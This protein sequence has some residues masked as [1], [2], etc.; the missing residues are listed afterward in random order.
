MPAD[1]PDTAKIGPTKYVTTP[2]VPNSQLRR[3]FQKLCPG[4]STSAMARIPNPAS[5]TL[6]IRFC[7]WARRCSSLDIR[8]LLPEDEL[9]CL[10]PE[11]LLLLLLLP[12]ARY[13]FLLFFPFLAELNVPCS[14]YLFT[15]ICVCSGYPVQRATIVDLLWRGGPCPRFERKF[16]RLLSGSGRPLNSIRRPRIKRL[17]VQ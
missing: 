12:E 16:F 8:F 9:L 7:C 5:T 11:L 1:R 6:R 2:K 10:A 13:V 14:P 15:I 3:T 17:S 4:T